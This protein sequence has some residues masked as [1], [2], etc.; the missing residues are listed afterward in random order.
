MLS[1]YPLTEAD[2]LS[3]QFTTSQHVKYH[4]FFI[5]Y[6]Y[7]FADYPLIAGNIYSVN[8]DVVEGD[9]NAAISD[10]RP[11]VTIVEVFKRF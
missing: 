8:I 6:S 10:E 1:P 11:G 9:S 2:D 7:M 5:D 3:Y 4:I